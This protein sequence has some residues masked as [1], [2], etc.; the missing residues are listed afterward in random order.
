MFT[1]NDINIY[2]FCWK[3]VVENSVALYEEI[4]KVCPNTFVI[5]CDENTQM[6]QDKIKHIQLDDSYYY[7]GQFETAIKETPI[8]RVVA[9][10]TGDVSP[11][12][13]WGSIIQKAVDAFNT[14]KVGVF[15][16]D[17]DYTFW[18]KKKRALW[19]N[20]WEVENTDCTIWFIHPSI[21]EVMR[22][23]PFKKICNLGWGADTV[24]NIECNTQNLLIARDYSEKVI[25]PHE[26]G[27]DGAVAN[28][29]MQKLLGIYFQYKSNPDIL[30]SI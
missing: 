9:C 7:G 28:I 18:T 10:I 6:D 22:P 2:I 15:A 26:T 17:V 8:G 14:G 21:I 12:A 5:N 19:A 11:V 23:F 3:K 16:P 13:N 24:V 29:Q 27:Y 4:S 1:I 20:L 30:L 25:H